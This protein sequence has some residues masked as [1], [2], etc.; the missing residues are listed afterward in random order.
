LTC[1][2]FYEASRQPRR[3]TPA[4]AARSKPFRPHAE[5]PALHRN[6]NPALAAGQPESGG[7]GA[8]RSAELRGADRSGQLLFFLPRPGG[9]CH[10]RPRR[11]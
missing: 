8:K 2:V 11:V 9:G 3:A 6:V 7:P 5:R 4:S 10:P 1:Q